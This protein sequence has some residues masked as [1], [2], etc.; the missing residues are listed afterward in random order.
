LAKS[1]PTFTETETKILRVLKD[2]EPHVRQDLIEAL[3]DKDHSLGSL[4]MHLCNLRRKTRPKGYDVICQ[5]LHRRIYYRAIKLLKPI[6]AKVKQ[7]PTPPK[8]APPSVDEVM[9]EAF[10]TG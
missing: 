2:G 6:P 8:P 7:R 3:P 1:R 9:D 5:L 4:S 10:G